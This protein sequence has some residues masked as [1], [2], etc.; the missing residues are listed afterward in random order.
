MSVDGT[1]W[2]KGTGWGWQW[3][4]DDEVGALNAMRSQSILDALGAVTQGRVFDLGVT[5]DRTSFLWAGH[6]ATE[7]VAFR[8]PAGLDL[9]ADQAGVVRDGLSFRTSMIVLSDHAG[10]QLDALS[11]ATFGDDHHWYNGFVA[12]EH[13]GDF[14]PQRAGAE[15]IPP[16]IL[17]AVLIDVPGYLGIDELDPGFA[18]DPTL[19]A[20][21]LAWQEVDI[22]PGDAVMIRSG[23]M[24]HWG[25]LGSDHA[26]LAR[27][28]TSGINLA[29]ARWLVEEKGAIL[30][31]SDTSTVEVMPAVD[32]DCSQ[33]VHEY[34]LVEQGVHMGELHTF[35]QLAV[36]RTY[37]FCY[38][39]LTPKVR[40]TTAGFALRPIALV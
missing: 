36:S 4:A 7:V 25:S 3:G 21:T 33:P 37:R 12:T 10:T 39:A 30:I 23:S 26:A 17:S 14:G 8:S 16:I 40:G 9:E 19:L 35:E 5:I 15:N 1:G 20:E 18:I 13:M 24:R 34:L 27:A 32:G 2:V 6:V 31:G 29:A 11:H 28:D 22:S 38:I